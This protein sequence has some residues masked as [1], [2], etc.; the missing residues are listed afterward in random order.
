VILALV[1][2]VARVPGLE[3]R[4]GQVALVRLHR[5]VAPWAVV[6]VV[7]HVALTSV[8]G[9]TARGGDPVQQLVVYV[10]TYPWM[11][12]ALAAAVMVVALSSAS[13]RRFL[14]ALR[15]RYETWWV[16]HLYLYLAVA[17]ALGHQLVTG[18]LFEDLP[19][20]RWAWGGLHLAVLLLVLVCRAGIPLARSL[21]HRLRIA[22]VVERPGWLELE[23]VGRDLGRLRGGQFAQWRVLRPGLWW[24]AHP[25]SVVPSHDGRSLRLVV[26]GDGDMARSLARTRPGTRL[27]FE[28]PYGTLTAARH[29]GAPLL[30]VA[31]GAGASAA[32]GVMADLR[33]GGDVVVLVRG[34]GA[35]SPLLAELREEG[36]R[37]GAEV[38]VLQG[39]RAQHPCDAEELLGLVPDLARRTAL[40]WGSASF[41]E[42]VV[43][44]LLRAGAAHVEHEAFA[45]GAS[46]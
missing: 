24:Q 22:R 44:E 8:G 4:Y 18:S 25:Y 2:L 20:L 40:V 31:G 36:R 12:P 5:L 17:L 1:V 33:A 26:S 46:S 9:A 34:R 21:H 3:S 11:L 45:F 42:H 7:L 15:V 23:I 37:I 30:L 43:P 35:T 39:D 16:S 14:A 32:L 29:A 27:W 6:A 28:G 41:V 19:P 10:T 13:W 38:R